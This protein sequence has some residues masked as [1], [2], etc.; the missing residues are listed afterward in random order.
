[1]EQRA[2]RAGN[3]A[4]SGYRADIDGLRGIAVT[5]VVCFHAGLVPF[6]SG[7]VGVDI[8][9]VISGFLIGAIILREAVEGRFSFARFYARR[10]RRILPALMV[11]IVFTA[12]AGS[13]LLTVNEFK[14]V[15]TLGT[16]ALVGAS[17]INL[18]QFQDYFAEDSRVRTLL[19]TWSLGVEEQFYVIFPFLVLLIVRFARAWLGAILVALTL[20]SFGLSL[21]WTRTAPASAFYLLPA[22]AWE[23]GVGVLLAAWEGGAGPFGGR[24]LKLPLPVQQ[25]LGCCGLATLLIGVTCFDEHMPFPG[26]LALLPVLGTAAVIASPNSLVSRTLLSWRP[27]V[28]VGLV[29][30]SW[31]LWHWP[32][33][34]LIRIIVPFALPV[35]VTTCIALASFA[36]AVASWRFVEQ[37][38][39]RMRLS[40]PSVLIR[41][42]CAMLV[43]AAATVAIQA[44]E[45]FPQRLS[46]KAAELERFVAELKRGECLNS[47][48]RTS[49]DDPRCRA[50]TEAKSVVAVLGDSHA[51]AVGPSLRQLAQREGVGFEIFAKSSCTP[52]LGVSVRLALTPELTGECTEFKD[53]ALAAIL[54]D[55]RVGTVVLAG[56]WAAGIRRQADRGFVSVPID[57]PTQ[58]GLTLLRTGLRDL[59]DTL[60]AAHKRVIILQDVPDIGIDPLTIALDEHIPARRALASLFDSD[61]LDMQSG[62]MPVSRVAR[63]DDVREAI[64]DVARTKP[65]AL[66]IDLFRHFCDRASCTF[67]VNGEPLYFDH[68][69]LSPVGATLALQGMALNLN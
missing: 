25:A 9:F 5:S 13:V 69:H 56:Y 45:G 3:P 61:L 41:S 22:R 2:I 29:S 62:R 67:I 10:A 57:D 53:K 47:N 6:A 68:H 34:S 39:R 17:N 46:P 64:V 18:W 30:Y 21:W 36:I 51:W 24:K 19:M 49:T 32:L 26:T 66:V 23:L 58:S 16:L 27:I 52:L 33:L 42:A 1:M 59:I 43:V 4:P 54:S 63:H 35:P 14:D 44:T 55:P 65:E 37:P 11:V 7:F 8:F 48:G 15:G 50:P 38:F 20:G 60:S 12:A 28:F 31:Y 40:V